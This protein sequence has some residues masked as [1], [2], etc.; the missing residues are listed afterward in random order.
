M[1][2]THSPPAKPLRLTQEEWRAKA[3]ALFGKDI[4]DWRF[5]CPICGHVQCINDFEQ[6]EGFDKDPLSVVYFSCIGRW[7]PERSDA[8]T[9]VDEK[10]GPCN[11]T[12]GGL[13]RLGPFIVTDKDG[14]EVNIFGFDDSEDPHE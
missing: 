14:E 12:C 6:L 9:E 13:F 7:M 2:I 8:F 1:G 3:V 5:K 11:Y 10:G 4:R